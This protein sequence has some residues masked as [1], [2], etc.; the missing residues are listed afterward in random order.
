MG[1]KIKN[2][3]NAYNDSA[4]MENMPM[5]LIFRITKIIYIS[6]GIIGTM[7]ILYWYFIDTKLPIEV[8]GTGSIKP[9]KAK[10]GEIV[11]VSWIVNKTKL[12]EGQ[13]VK[14]LFGE[15]GVHL[16][17]VED[18]PLQKTNGPVVVN[19]VFRVPENARYGN[20]EFNTTVHYYCNPLQHLFPIIYKFPDVEFKVIK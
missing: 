9:Y 7:C 2:H 12:C 19:I 11:T 6:L 16:L 17:R 10:R 20:C 8:T 5:D 18:P 14:S 3:N 15:C 4:R 13:S 1:T